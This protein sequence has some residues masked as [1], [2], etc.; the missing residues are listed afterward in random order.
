MG[1]EGTRARSHAHGKRHGRITFHLLVVSLAIAAVAFAA[2]FP[3]ANANAHPMDT[4]PTFSLSGVVA[5]NGNASTVYF[6]PGTSSQTRDS[7][8]L[9]IGVAD[10]ASVRSAGAVSPVSSFS[11]GV[12]AASARSGEVGAG[13]KP[14]AEIV[15][16]SKPFV[17]YQTQ[18]GD[19][20]SGVAAKFGISLGTLLDNNPTVEDK[21]LIQK[22]QELVVPRKDGILYKV[23]HGDTVDKVV[24]QYDNI[25]RDQ[26]IS[27]RPNGLSEGASVKV[28][29]Y[30]LLIG[31]TLK[32]PPPPPPAPVV[33]QRPTGGV[34][35]GSAPPASAGKFNFPLASWRAVSDQ[36]GTNR[37]A[38]RIHEGIDLDLYGRNGS[39][40][41][42]ACNGVVSRTEYLTYSYGYH[43]IVDCGDGFTTL[44]AHMSEILVSPGQ[45]VSQG[46]ILGISGITGFTTGEHLHFEIRINGAP[47]NPAFYLAF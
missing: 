5:G 25:T 37:G 13:T 1:I 15:D 35:T 45:R 21:N 33:V 2:R 39:N 34:G 8:A 36:F 7:V 31:A 40:I 16:P 44:Y 12:S 28:G 17:L 41:F 9:L 3:E 43:V 19:S 42:S 6:R 24:A 46:T 10:V 11:A 4:L 14:L 32:P 20:V 18:A 23:G 38:G 27:Y 22:G 47:V 29:D 30:L 26:A